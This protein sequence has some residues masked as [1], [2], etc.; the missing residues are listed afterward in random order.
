MSFD[1]FPFN[2]L[3]MWHMCAYIRSFF[4]LVDVKS[5]QNDS[6]LVI[7]MIL[8]CLSDRTEALHDSWTYKGTQ[9]FWLLLGKFDSTVLHLF[10][11]T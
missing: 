6:N 5:S 1:L 10:I 2:G 7:S 9:Y 8:F 11:L 3:N 4:N